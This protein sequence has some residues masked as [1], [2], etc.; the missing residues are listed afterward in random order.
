M[1]IPNHH[2]YISL[3]ATN[4]SDSSNEIMV[5]SF[6]LLG[7]HSLLHPRTQDNMKTIMDD[8][9][10]VLHRA[11]LDPVM[12]GLIEDYYFNDTLVNPKSKVNFW[13]DYEK[14]LRQMMSAYGIPS[15]FSTNAC[16][17]PVIPL[18][19]LYNSTHWRVHP[20]YA[21]AFNSW[22]TSILLDSKHKGARISRKLRELSNNEPIEK[23]QDAPKTHH[24]HPPA[25]AHRSTGL[26]AN[27]HFCCNLHTL[28]LFRSQLAPI[29]G[30]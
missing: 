20:L 1:H 9:A 17:Q 18:R 15:Q 10:Y 26:D 30:I 27:D 11:H 22:C 25:P 24:H 8:N 4:G 23:H 21:K 14:R 19:G 16:Q 13:G 2:A 28:E 6:G 29:A 12:R 3:P 5:D 7:I